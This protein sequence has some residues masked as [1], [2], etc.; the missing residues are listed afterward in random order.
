MT[1]TQTRANR[2][3][4]GGRYRDYRKKRKYERGSS[5]VYTKVGERRVSTIRSRG[6]YQKFKILSDNTA[7]VYDPKTKKY[8][9]LK[10]N[11]ILET[12]AN[13]HFVR[14]NIMTK[15]TIIETEKG[16]AKITN[17]PGQENIINAVLLEK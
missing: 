1:I 13:R 15:G 12:P 2:K 9:K 6:N 7:N 5:P 11:T 3:L 10:I 16:R 14:R 17:R 8:L 4:T